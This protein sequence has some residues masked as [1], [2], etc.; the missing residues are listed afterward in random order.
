MFIC[1]FMCI[2]QIKSCRS[3]WFFE[4]SE[5]GKPGG[6]LAPPDSDLQKASQSLPRMRQRGSKGVLCQGV[7]LTQNTSQAASV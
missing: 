6:A 1:F 4:E 3:I 2:F 7:Y 5:Q